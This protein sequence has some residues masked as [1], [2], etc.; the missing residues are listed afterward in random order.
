MRKTVSLLASTGAAGALLLGTAIPASADPN[1]PNV[2]ITGVARCTAS[3]AQGVAVTTTAGESDSSTVSATGFYSLSLQQVPA[4]GAS[5]TFSVQCSSPADNYSRTITI[6]RP[7]SGKVI[8][9]NL[10]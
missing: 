6:I 7:L 3:V 9:V 1:S 8:T 5:A 10:F 2:G 4:A